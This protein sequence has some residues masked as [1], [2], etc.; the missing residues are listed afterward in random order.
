MRRSRP[1]IY[2]TPA[3]I[4]RHSPNVYEVLDSVS[5]TVALTSS[6]HIAPKPESFLD[7]HLVLGHFL[8]VS[9]VFRTD[10]CGGG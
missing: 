4:S 9:V 2:Y 5:I 10:E 7:H 8:S 1:L 3:I 6:S